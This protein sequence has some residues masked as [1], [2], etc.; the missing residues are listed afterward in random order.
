MLQKKPI[1][2]HVPKTGGRSIRQGL[3]DYFDP[4]DTY[5]HSR[6]KQ[7]ENLDRKTH[8][9]FS[10]VRN[11]YERVLSAHQYLVNGVGNKRD[12]ENAKNLQKNFKDFVKYDL[13]DTF[14]IHFRPIK[15]WIDMS[16]DFIG[17]YENLQ[18]D[19]DIVCKIIGIEPRV[20]PQVGLGISRAHYSTF[21]DKETID[22]VSEFYKEDIEYYNYRYEEV[23]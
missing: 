22:I 8:F 4:Q 21:Y 19:F 2:A 3:K 1:F 15:W 9:I 6:A 23:N 14:N 7:F 13:R 16:V 11:P 10:F 20:L 18:S 5:K 12:T 17:R